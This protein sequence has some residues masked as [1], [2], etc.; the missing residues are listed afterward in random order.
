MDEIKH[1]EALN[2]RANVCAYLMMHEVSFSYS[3]EDGLTFSAPVFFVCQ[4]KRSL[5]NSYG[6]EKIIIN[7]IK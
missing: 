2:Y 1:W 5:R 7:E 3:D 6:C 4:M